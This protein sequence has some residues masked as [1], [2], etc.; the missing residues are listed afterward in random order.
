MSEIAK[1]LNNELLEKQFTQIAPDMKWEAERGFAIQ[2]LKANDYLMNLATQNPESLQA[3]VK[4][5][6]SIGL[7]LSP[8]EKLAYLIPRKGKVCLDISYMGLCRIATNSGSIQWVQAQLVYSN[9]KFSFVGAGEKPV[10]EFDPFATIE[11]RGEFRGGYCVAKTSGGDFLTTMMSADEIYGIRD[12]SE[13][14]KAFIS[15]KKL[16][17]WVTDFVPMAC[18]TIVRR[19]FNMWPRTDQHSLERMAKAVQISND[20]EGIEMATSSPDLGQYSDEAKVYFDQLIT[21]SDAVGMVVFK[22]TKT[23]AEWNN[24]YHS[25]D[26]GQKGKYQK[27]IDSLYLK[28]ESMVRDYVDVINEAVASGEE[29]ETHLEEMD[30]LRPLVET[31]VSNE[32]QKAMREAV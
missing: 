10:H 3:A 13:A 31:R 15:K 16:C 11:Q 27:V 20:N 32:A 4:N 14:Y 22:H 8:A 23:E 2:I 24:L 12:R 26:K 28:G 6:A 25:F 9:D 30:D 29:I 1:V 21:A 7:S 5:V 18:K 19:A 17:P